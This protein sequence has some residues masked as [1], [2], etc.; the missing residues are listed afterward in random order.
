MS[1]HKSAKSVPIRPYLSANKDCR[2]GRFI[3]V[4]NSLLLSKKFQALKGKA[5]ILYFA[6]AMEAGGQLVVKLSHGG[7]ER[8]YGIAP[9]TY[10][11]SVKELIAAGFLEQVLDDDQSQFATNVFRFS[12]SWKEA[13]RNRE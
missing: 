11:R 2:E 12:T 9:T 3:Q 13:S 6:L 1:R 5:Q 10:D 7:A 4:G 8:K